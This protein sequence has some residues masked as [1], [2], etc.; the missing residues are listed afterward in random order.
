MPLVLRAGIKNG[1]RTF[2]F[3]GT[4]SVFDSGSA[5]FTI[6]GSVNAAMLNLT[7][8]LADCGVRDGM[9]EV[10]DA[11]AFLASERAFTVF[12]GAIV[13]SRYLARG[14]KAGLCNR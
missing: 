6:G 13:D 11:V 10:A 9:H 8:C 2:E 5:E 12:R 3:R 4:V 1:D 7:K 14:A